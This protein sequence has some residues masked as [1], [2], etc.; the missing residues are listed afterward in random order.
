MSLINS[1]AI[2]SSG[3]YEIDQ[4]LRFNDDDSAYLSKTFASAG[5]RKT[6]TW[7][8]WVK[9]GAGGFLF[10]SH[11]GNNNADYG[12]VEI[13]GDGYFKFN[14]YAAHACQSVAL[15]R[16]SSAWYHLMCVMDTTQATEANRIKLYINGELATKTIGA[17]HPSQNANMSINAAAGHSI[18]SRNPFGS[19]HYFDGYIGEVNFVDGQALTPSDFGETGN[20]RRV[21]AYRV[22]R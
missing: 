14:S 15:L 16:D 10:F 21:E 19:S 5:N 6:W 22:F 20:I 4:S 13:S 2:P 7:S 17:S 18:S 1:T 3:G 8:G 11:S 9:N 12:G